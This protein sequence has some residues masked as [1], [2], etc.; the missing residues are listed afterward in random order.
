MDNTNELVRSWIATA[1]FAIRYIRQ[2]NRGTYVAMNQGVRE[3]AGEFFASLD[4]DDRYL[5]DALERFLS[6]WETIPHDERDHFAGICGLDAL[7]SGEIVGTRFP[8][9]VFDSNNVDIRLRHRVKGD[10]ISLMRTAVMR[11]FPFPEDC[12]RFVTPAVVWNRIGRKYQTR[13]VNEVF[14]IVEYQP[15]GL[16]AKSKS[17][18]INHPRSAV[19]VLEELINSN[20]LPRVDIALKTY[21]NY[22]RLSLHLG[23]GVWQQLSRIRPTFLYFLCLPLGFALAWSD[24]VLLSRNP[25]REP[26]SDLPQ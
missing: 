17:L 18:I 20:E 19:L 25:G 2:P 12:G 7:E 4:S 1:P 23:V 14:A 8:Q 15:G 5:P 10:K 21:A 11:E 16:T 24:R 13:F 3:A 6:H 26:K 22:I 9:D